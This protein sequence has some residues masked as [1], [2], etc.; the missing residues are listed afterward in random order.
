[1]KMI[2]AL[3]L[4]FLAINISFVCSNSLVFLG[5]VEVPEQAIPVAVEFPVEP[6]IDAVQFAEG[7]NEGF[8]FFNNLPAQ[9]SCE[10]KG[11][12]LVGD[13]VAIYEILKNINKDTNFPQLLV[14]VFARLSDGI[15][16]FEEIGDFCKEWTE[17]I[18][19]KINGL[20]Q[21]VEKEAYLERLALHALTSIG[22]IKD[23]ITAGVELIKAQNFHDG[24]KK[25]GEV[26][27]DIFFWD[28]KN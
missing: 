13:V 3:L 6:L 1:M 16:Q 20:V 23:A 18:K 9:A 21:H 12:L 22:R 10:G 8:S 11:E 28:Y 17:Q 5:E 7:L 24:G 26:A 25:F 27:K 4:V 15:K 2:K 14:D 19:N